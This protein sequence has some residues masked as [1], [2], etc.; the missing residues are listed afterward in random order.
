MKTSKQNKYEIK[1]SHINDRYIEIEISASAYYVMPT[2][3][4]NILATSK[5]RKHNDRNL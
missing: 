1:H 4:E 2:Q 5:K 3:E